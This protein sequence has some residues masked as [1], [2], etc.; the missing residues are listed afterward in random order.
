MIDQHQEHLDNSSVKNLFSGSWVDDDRDKMIGSL[1]IVD[2]AIPKEI[3]ELSVG[4]PKNKS[5]LYER[6]NITRCYQRKGSFV[7]MVN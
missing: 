5:E 7:D 4:E 6:L 2:A 1:N 3:D